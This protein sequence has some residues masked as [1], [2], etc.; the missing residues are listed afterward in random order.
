MAE[1]EHAIDALP[2][3]NQIIIRK[4]DIIIDGYGFSVML[5]KRV[6]RGPFRTFAIDTFLALVMEDIGIVAVVIDNDIP[7]ALGCVAK[8]VRMKRII[9]G[10]NY[11]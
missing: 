1:Y 10:A 11:Y 6:Q 7:V 3:G 2:V 5:H 8:P 9:A 4:P